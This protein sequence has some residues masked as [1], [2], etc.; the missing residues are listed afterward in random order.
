ML[1]N[2]ALSCVDVD[3]PVI[4]VL[5]AVF[6]LRAHRGINALLR[7]WCD[8]RR[9]IG[10]ETHQNHASCLDLIILCCV[11]PTCERPGVIVKR[12]QAGVFSGQLV[13]VC[14]CCFFFF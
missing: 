1:H 11:N 13:C 9:D 12:V 14:V 7:F 2:I 10:A 4:V 3:A 6:S 5:N 8:G